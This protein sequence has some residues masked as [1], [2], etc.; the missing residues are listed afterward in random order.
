MCAQRFWG[1]TEADYSDFL[2]HE[3]TQALESTEE[4]ATADEAQNA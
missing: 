2:T 1:G 4:N 3:E